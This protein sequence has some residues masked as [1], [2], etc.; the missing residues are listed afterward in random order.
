MVYKKIAASLPNTDKTRNKIDN[1]H[2]SQGWFDS[3]VSL[4]NRL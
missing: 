1:L 3:S 2:V 4:E